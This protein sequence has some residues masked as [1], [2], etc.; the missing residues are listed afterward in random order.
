MGGQV[1]SL[2]DDE[3][4]VGDAPPPDVGQG[5]QLQQILVYQVAYG[6]VGLVV[7]ETVAPVLGEDEFQVV[8][9]GLHPQVEF[10]ILG[11]GQVADVLAHWDDRPGHQQPLESLLVHRPHQAGGQGQEGLAGT[12]LAHQGDQGYGVVHQALQGETLLPVEGADP[13]GIALGVDQRDQ[14]AIGDVAG[15]GGVLGISLVHQGAELVRQQVFPGDG[16]LLF[17]EE[18]V[19]LPLCDGVL[20]AAGVE[21]GEGDL[22]FLEILGLYAQGVGFDPGVEILADE[23]DPLS[24]GLGLLLFLHQLE[25]GQDDLVVGHRLREAPEAAVV[26]REEDLEGAASGEVHAAGELSRPPVPVQFP[27][28]FPGA[29][30]PLIPVVL[31]MVQLLDD[32]DGED[33][34]VVG[35]LV[36]GVGIVDEDVGVQDEVFSRHI[37]HDYTTPRMGS[38]PENR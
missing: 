6:I 5:F 19:Y 25:G 16:Q 31:E 28:G 21:V 17:P 12:R 18:T 24:L 27:G 11:A 32:L 34:T 7:A 29:S 22:L 4:L 35:E 13:P 37:R 36:N 26:L 3:V 20:T 9:D 8:E 15:Q 2:V 30:G 1:L 10:L 14:S 38:S 23:D 33:D